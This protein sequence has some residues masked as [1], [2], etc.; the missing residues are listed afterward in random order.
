MVSG[1]ATHVTWPLNEDYCR[2]MLL[3][4]WPDWFDIQEV[5]G[6]TESWIDRFTGFISSDEYPAFVKAQ[7]AKAQR[8]AEHP[9]EQVFEDDTDY[10]AAEAEEQPDWVDVYAGQ[11][12]RY[13]G[14][15][16]DFDFDDGGEDYDWNSTCTV[17]PEGKDPKKWLDEMI[18][19]DEERH[20][21]AL[22]L[23]QVSPFS[24]NENQ[25]AIVSLVLYTLYNFAEKRPDY[26]PLRLVVSGTAGTGKSY[27]IKCLQS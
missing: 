12:Q 19:D 25:R 4:H 9:Q 20:T 8:Y 6:D 3:L 24:L 5:K 17:L 13:E 11:N 10:D 22:E 18:K 23:P 7:V 27:V 1:G 2:T 15:E 16:K 21:V 26:R 14:V